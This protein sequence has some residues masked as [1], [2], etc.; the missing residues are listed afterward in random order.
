MFFVSKSD[1]HIGAIGYIN[2]NRNL[3]MRKIMEHNSLLTSVLFP[4]SIEATEDVCLWESFSASCAAD[5]FVFVERALYGRMRNNRCF[6][7]TE[8]EFNCSID[9]RIE[10]QKQIRLNQ[11]IHL[12]LSGDF[13]TTKTPSC[14]QGRMP[15][16]EIS[17][18]CIMRKS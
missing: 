5:E 14:L 2:Q 3:K 1:G 7:L 15:F 16:L 13:F 11:R 6:N 8:N 12:K 9:I 17:Y 18:K 10:T 4:V